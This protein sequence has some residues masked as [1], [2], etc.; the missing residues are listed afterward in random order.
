MEKI[1][2]DQI[3]F[4]G[5]DYTLS[6][7][8]LPTGSVVEVLIDGRWTAGVVSDDGTMGTIEIE[9]G[10]GTKALVLLSEGLVARWPQKRT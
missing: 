5:S 10:Y 3:A 7:R 6:S 2:L 1:I 8:P 4:D 9:Q